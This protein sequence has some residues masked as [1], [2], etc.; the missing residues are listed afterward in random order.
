MHM[1]NYWYIEYLLSYR[2]S[3]FTILRLILPLYFISRRWIPSFSPLAPSPSLP[4]TL[5]YSLSTDWLTAH[6]SALSCIELNSA[7]LTH[8]L[9]SLTEQNDSLLTCLLWA[10]LN[11]TVPH[12]LAHCTQHRLT[13]H[14]SS[15]TFKEQN[16]VLARTSLIWKILE[17]SQTYTCLRDQLN[18]FSNKQ[19]L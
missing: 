3:P 2:P 6:L 19:E 10:A 13:I 5:P 4:W 14:L 8:W 15:L 17:S 11:S 18:R 1:N 9:T 12:P 16:R 7:L